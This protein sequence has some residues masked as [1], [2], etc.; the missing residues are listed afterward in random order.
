MHCR[1]LAAAQYQAGLQTLCRVCVVHINLHLLRMPYSVPISSICAL[2]YCTAL[3]FA[4]HMCNL[5]TWMCRRSGKDASM[6]KW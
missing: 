6:S 5:S 3:S 1:R 2:I 4:S